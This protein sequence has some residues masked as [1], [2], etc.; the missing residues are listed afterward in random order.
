MKQNEKQFWS[1]V[2]NKLYSLVYR[3]IY[4][5]YRF[6]SFLIIIY[7]QTTFLLL[8]IWNCFHICYNSS[9]YL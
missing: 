3:S 5:R 2:G 1:T 4:L 8:P 7:W 9:T 6:D